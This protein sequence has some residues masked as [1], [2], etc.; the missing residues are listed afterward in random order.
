[1][2]K[3]LS[4]LSF[5]GGVE[6]CMRMQIQ[7]AHAQTYTANATTELQHREYCCSWNNPKICIISVVGGIRDKNQMQIDA[8]CRKCIF[9]STEPM[10]MAMAFCFNL[11]C[12]RISIFYPFTSSDLEFGWKQWWSSS[13]PCKIWKIYSSVLRAS[14]RV[15]LFEHEL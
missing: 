2:A 11:L 4:Q 14:L 7:N 13:S 3:W 1:M 5:R 10:R 12:A 6:E 9:V 8:F 15:F